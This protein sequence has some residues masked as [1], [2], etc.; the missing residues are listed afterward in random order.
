MF[1]TNFLLLM[2]VIGV[3]A[4]LVA[5]MLVL[6]AQDAR[7]ASAGFGTKTARILIPHYTK[8]GVLAATAIPLA[9]LIFGSC[10]FMLREHLKAP[11][12]AVKADGP[13]VIK[14]RDLGIGKSVTGRDDPPP[15]EPVIGKTPTVG[16]PTP[17]PPEQAGTEDGD[18]QSDW[19]R[20]AAGSVD[21]DKLNREI[22]A[23]G[24]HIPPQGY[25]ALDKYP[26]LVKR[27]DPV[28][29][30]IAIISGSQGRVCVQALLDIDGKVLRGEVSQSSG[31]PALDQAAVEAVRQWV[32][33]P[34]IAPDG[35]PARVWQSCPIKFKLSH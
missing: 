35:K 6:K 7:L 2:P 17:V 8:E 12:T 4:G 13:I 26:E 11:I 1:T 21:L 32:F 25:M 28:Y 31:N 30:S 34:A 27:I 33:T 29:P 24:D 19:A 20:A 18:T 3:A 22:V 10:V 23:G 14:Y 15:V 16:V 9:I 5:A